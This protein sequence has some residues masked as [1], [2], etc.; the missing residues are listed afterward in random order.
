[1]GPLF[2]LKSCKPVDILLSI[3]V[4][5]V[6]FW[7]LYATASILFN[8][9]NHSSI[10]RRR[11]DLAIKLSYKLLLFLL[12]PLLIHAQS[13]GSG[14]DINEIVKVPLSPEAAAFEKY[15][16]VPV[17][18]YT[19]TP[20][21]SVP[22]GNI[23]GKEVSVPV[24]LTF[25]ASGI[26]VTQIATWS[27]LGTNLNVGGMVTRQ[28][29]GLPDGYGGHELRIFDDEMKDFINFARYDEFGT[30]ISLD[31]DLI[32]KWWS[33]QTEVARKNADTQP[34]MFSFSANGMSGTIY[35]NYETQE[36][37]CL[38]NP[39]IRVTMDL[40]L[41]QTL[42]TN[43]LNGWEI[44]TEDG[45]RY[46]FEK[47]EITRH[48]FEVGLGAMEHKYV[49][50]WYLTEIFS[51]SG[52]DYFQFTYDQD[53]EWINGQEWLEHASVASNITYNH[54]PT[55]TDTMSSYI[56]CPEDRTFSPVFPPYYQYLIQQSH[57]NYIYL[58]GKKAAFFGAGGTAG[59]TDR[60]DLEGRK[61]IREIDFYDPTG[62]EITR[63]V[64]FFHSY[65]GYQGTP[66]STVQEA[67]IRLKLDKLIIR[68]NG[69][70]GGDPQEY[71][72]EY[73]DPDNIPSRYAKSIDFWGYNN[74][75]NNTTLIPRLEDITYDDGTVLPGANRTPS[76]IYTQIGTLKKI[77][78]PT[79]GHTEFYYGLHVAP[80]TNNIS[81]E[82]EYEEVLELQGGLSLT[83]DYNYGLSNDD[84]FSSIAP[85]DIPAGEDGVFILRDDEKPARVRIELIGTPDPMMIPAQYLAIYR[86]GDGNCIPVPG[87]NLCAYGPERKYD[88]ILQGIPDL[89]V[90]ENPASRGAFYEFNAAGWAEG[91]YRVLALNIDPNI[92]IRVTFIKSIRVTNTS[93]QIIGGLR[94]NKTV[95]RTADGV[96]ALTTYYYYNDISSVDPANIADLSAFSAN[97][98]SSAVNHLPLV[99]HD[100]SYFEQCPPFAPYYFTCTTTNRYATNLAK[101][102]GPHIAY[103]AVSEI[104]FGSNAG[105]NGFTVNYFFNE[106]EFVKNIPLARRKLKNGN[107][108]KS[109]VYNSGGDLLEETEH[110]VSLTPVNPV[111]SS[112][113][114]KSS[115]GMVLELQKTFQG[116]RFKE[117]LGNGNAS[118]GFM[119]FC[120]PTTE[121][122]ALPPPCDG[123]QVLC[124]PGTFPINNRVFFA[125]SSYW[126]KIDRIVKTQYFDGIPIETVTEYAYN[127]DIHRQL[128][129]TK[130]TNSDGSVR[131]NITYY[132][133]DINNPN[134]SGIFVNNESTIIKQLDKNSLHRINTPIFQEEYY[135]NDRVFIQKT[136]FDDFTPGL[137]SPFPLNILPTQILTA[138]GNL[139]DLR[140]ALVFNEYDLRGNPLD[141]SRGIGV[142]QAFLWGHNFSLP[143]AKVIHAQKGE[144]AFTSFEEDGNGSG[145]WL[146]AGNRNSFQSMSGKFSFDMQGNSLVAQVHPPSPGNKTYIVSYW[147]QGAPATVSSS[148]GP[149]FTEVQG[150]WTYYEHEIVINGSAAISVS[151]NGLIDELRLHPKEAQMISYAYDKQGR[152]ISITDPHSRSKHYDYNG[153]NQLSEVRDHNRDLRQEIKYNYR[154]Q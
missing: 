103:S 107:L 67:D 28:V 124:V 93:P 134:L 15:G 38:D 127:N 106:Q 12:C 140:Q 97:Y 80:P 18:M 27:G 76:S 20:N 141:I 139:N 99:F 33:I 3:G 47:K 137:P 16:K 17:S 75:I 54:G 90:N 147:K 85:T 91:A 49:S 96:D 42:V 135:D 95:D 123:T 11:C 89:V 37:Y 83:D 8:H 59:R 94:T 109:K 61:R 44:T 78:Y 62:D 52:K 40:D 64:D 31:E 125:H 6:S 70:G 145:G 72:F 129:E 19:G 30:D 22:L 152:I 51:P 48:L 63:S 146:Y 24:S 34:D 119:E 50:A 130:V 46:V 55:I 133:D 4:L 131:A 117:L 126:L 150:N 73:I 142:H 132:P 151:G 77:Y 100:F 102:L 112:N 36:A 120:G 56:G 23:Q 108:Q 35:I 136:I 82:E 74:G 153:Q 79:G 53:Q 32:N 9:I 10:M 118:F 5:P 98:T 57:L 138:T 26:K 41:S 111:P 29:N 84:Y 115:M 14:P 25:D 104:Q 113:L 45:S 65:F 43:Q 1:M 71:S 60:A 105:I 122:Q 68:G 114:I 58:N 81:Y 149:D 2:Y 69:V 86:S 148:V 121:L 39:N 128:S 66:P 143:I 101:A 92:T 88:E 7:K 21:I 116:L 110:F 144:V 13:G 87:G 154:N